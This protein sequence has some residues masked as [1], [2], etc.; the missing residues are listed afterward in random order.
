MGGLSETACRWGVSPPLFM[1]EGAPE[2]PQAAPNQ[3]IERM[4]PFVQRA[5]ILIVGRDV[6]KRSKS[7]L[8]FILVTTDTSENSLAQ[9]LQDYAH[10][11]VVRCYTSADLEKHFALKGT[12]V[13]GFA[14]SGLAQSI[15]AELKG[16]RI[17]K[18]VVPQQRSKSQPKNTPP[19]HDAKND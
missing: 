5:H 11:P 13:V 7:K 18:P 19:R 1:N 14:K 6:L 2:N 17:N 8:H 3:S 12:K 10:Y 4:F 9:I 16:F 15:Y